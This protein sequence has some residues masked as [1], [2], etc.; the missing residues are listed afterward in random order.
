M[1][2]ITKV[3][4]GALGASAMLLSLAGPALADGSPQTSDFVAVGS[5]TVQNASN[6]LFD[7]DQ[8]GNPG[9]NYANRASRVFSFDANGDDN[10]RALYPASSTTALAVTEILRAGTLPVAR[11]NGSGS[12]IAA[13]TADS[14][15]GAGYSTLPNGNINIVRASRF[16]KPAEQTACAAIADCGGLHVFQFATDDL[17]VATAVTTNATAALTDL[18]LAHIYQCDAG[19]TN[20]NGTL[21]GTS[22]DAIIPV[23]PQSGSGTRSFF[24]ADLH[25]AL[26]TFSA[27]GSTLGSC[28]VTGQEHDPTSITSNVAKQDVVMPF[29]T[30]KLALINGTEPGGKAYFGTTVAGTIMS[31]YSTGGYDAP[32]GLFFIVRDFDLANAAHYSPSAT[33]NIYSY[34]F[35]GATSFIARGSNNGL[36][37][38]AGLTPAYADLGDASA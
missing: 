10:G 9:F 19:Y 1:R 18:Q 20:W 16:P 24:L 28:V 26:S 5:D 12:G 15:G 23:I 29:S 13:I 33:K 22:A 4:L 3:G 17:Q 6:F 36:I 25:A 30:G 37:Q 2:K 32:R 38:S 8:N 21:G 31:N 11:P 7:G 35:S 34:L 14:I 27:T